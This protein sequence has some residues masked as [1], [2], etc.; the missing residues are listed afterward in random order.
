MS[1][2]IAY[3][4]EMVEEVTIWAVEA[5]LLKFLDYD[6]ALHF[7]R[8]GTE[9]ELQHAVAFEVKCSGDI[10]CRQHIVEV[11]EVGA[12]PGIAFSSC[13]F[14]LGVEGRDIDRSAE[15]EVLEQVCH[16]GELSVFIA[17]ADVVQHIDGSHGCGRVI[18]MHHTQA[19]GKRVALHWY[20]V[21]VHSLRTFID[22][23][24]MSVL[25]RSALSV[26]AFSI[27]STVSMPSITSPNTVYAPSR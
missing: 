26:C 25:G 9:V 22:S 27:L 10:L 8:A 7:E 3:A 24:R 14:E 2:G 5:C 19:V 15:H 20:V 18:R 17:R 13:A 11:G 21:A 6:S 1:L 4:S 16:A 12:R 23:I